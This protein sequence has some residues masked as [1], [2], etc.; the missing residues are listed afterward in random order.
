[1]LAELQ[2]RS[3]LVR[4]AMRIVQ[5]EFE[6]VLDRVRQPDHRIEAH[7]GCHALERV[8][9]PHHVPQRAVVL[10][11]VPQKS[12]AVH[13]RGQMLTGL[14]EEQ[15]DQFGD[16][17]R[18]FHM[19]MYDVIKARRLIKL[20]DQIW[21]QV[22]RAASVFTLV[23]ERAVVAFEEHTLILDAVRDR[24]A[25]RTKALVRRHK[26]AG[27]DAAATVLGESD[28]SQALATA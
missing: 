24:D 14:A 28:A 17:N 25:D 8:G 16:L 13:R 22:P 11:I 27:R 21:D 1:M 3:A 23:P 5:Q 15:F 10:G 19:T 26:L 20:I 9:P 6:Q 7:G 2:K 4:R 18:L 12:D